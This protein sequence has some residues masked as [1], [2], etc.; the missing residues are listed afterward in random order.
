MQIYVIY[1]SSW[2][3]YSFP[4]PCSNELIDIFAF[5]RLLQNHKTR[6]N[7]SDVCGF[8]AKF[9]TNNGNDVDL[10]KNDN[11]QRE[12]IVIKATETWSSAT[13]T[14]SH[15]ETKTIEQNVQRISLNSNVTSAQNASDTSSPI[16]N[17]SRTAQCNE[18]SAANATK[19]N[20]SV[21]AS[22]AASDDK[23]KIIEYLRKQLIEKDLEIEKLRKLSQ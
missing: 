12:R 2:S 8:V 6:P 3:S 14:I 11:N 22:L 13:S 15:T 10:P 16:S 21:L 5:Y 20:E 23:D 1:L 4:N 19:D 17:V 7:A 9:N 18:S